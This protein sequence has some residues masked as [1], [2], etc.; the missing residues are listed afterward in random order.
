MVAY[1]QNELTSAT[2]ISKQFGKY[3][4]NVSSGAVEKLAI[5]KNNKIEAVL[6]PASVYESLMALL[7][8]KENEAIL[9]TIKTRLQIP[10]EAYRN[11]QDVLKALDLSVDE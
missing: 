8:D 6:L 9:D 4:S 3:L 7:D 10:K 5:L 11:G 1:A 2:E